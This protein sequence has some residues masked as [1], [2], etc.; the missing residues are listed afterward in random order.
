LSEPGLRWPDASEDV[1]LAGET[2]EL[3][4][5]FCHVLERL[6]EHNTEWVQLHRSRS[7]NSGTSEWLS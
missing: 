7:R 2:V 3:I 5:R 4:E 6:G 1:L